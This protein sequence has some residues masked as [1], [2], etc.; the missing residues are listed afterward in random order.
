MKPYQERVVV[1]KAELDTKRDN[2][3]AFIG[4]AQYRALDRAEQVRLCRQLDAM[5]LYS[6]ILLERIAAF[7]R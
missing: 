7:P 4:G 5:K 2:L 3:I 6:G 1:E